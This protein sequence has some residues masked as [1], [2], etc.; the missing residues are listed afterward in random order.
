MIGLPMKF[1]PLMALAQHHGVPTRLLDWSR[2]PLKAACFAA[3]K[4]WAQPDKTGRLSVWALCVE[5][6][7]MLGDAP[8]PFTVITAPAASNSNLRAQ[9][10]LFTLAKRIQM[11]RETV[12]RTTFD[13]LLRD[14]VK[15]YNIKPRGPWFHRIT[16]PQHEAGA[17]CLALA[18]EGVS[19]AVLFQTF[20]EWRSQ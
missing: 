14:W 13:E 18:L 16:L 12:T 17:L 9:E 1:C 3:L 6:L 15:Q 5:R 8:Q 7:D 19:R 2:N 4:A 20:L 11:N 10:G